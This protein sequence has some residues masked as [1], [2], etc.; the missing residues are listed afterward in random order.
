[1]LAFE[2]IAA[3]DAANI[4]EAADGEMVKQVIINL[5]KNAL[6]S[7]TGEQEQRLTVRTALKDGSVELTVAD[8]GCGVRP[9][10]M[11]ELFSPFFTT[12]IGGVGLGLSVSRQIVAQ[13]GGRIEVE[14]RP[15]VG[16]QFVVTFGTG[17]AQEPPEPEG[18]QSATGP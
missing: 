1:M 14:S 17:E 12:T 2:P 5:I 6:E 11:G 9:E 4:R 13:H 16:S 7:M 8:T 15:G 18:A 3:N 10:S